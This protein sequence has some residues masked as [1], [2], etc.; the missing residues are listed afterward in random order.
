[1]DKLADFPVLI[2]VDEAFLQVKSHDV[3]EFEDGMYGISFL[4]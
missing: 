4:F 1:L 2:F 3:E